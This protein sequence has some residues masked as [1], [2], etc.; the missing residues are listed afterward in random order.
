MPGNFTVKLGDLLE[1]GVQ[2]W[3]M[4]PDGKY[5][6]FDEDYRML[7]N[8][9]IQDH[10]YMWEIGQETVGQFRFALNRKMRE[11]M[12]LY[13]Q[14]Y[15]ST[16]LE[17]DPF[18]TNKYVDTMVHDST[19]NETRDKSKNGETTVSVNAT[20]TRDTDVTS[21]ESET[22]HN[23][24]TVNAVQDTTADAASRVVASETPQ[25]RLS[26]DEDYATGATDTTSRTATHGTNASDTSQDGTRGTSG[27]DATR[28]AGTSATESLGSETETDH[29]TG[30]GRNE[31]TVTRTID[32]SKG[33]M[34]ELLMKYRESLLNIDMQVVAELETL[35]MLIWDNGDEFS[36]RMHR[37]GFAYGTSSA[38]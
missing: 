3:D 10:Y 12:P 7:L 16:L 37:Y 11:I 34:P 15:E 23:T 33:H 26:G 35:F 2:I 21:T 17:L 32:A 4:S 30:T 13:N 14:L 8:R 22:T 36:G 6:V 29:E 25:V 24:A 18:R 27:T 20:D 28:E 38:L 19:S 5:P 1:D 9:K 31:G